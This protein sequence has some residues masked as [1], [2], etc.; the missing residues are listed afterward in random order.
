MKKKPYKIAAKAIIFQGS[1]VLILRK[2]FAE[3][4]AKDTHGWDFPG[5]GLEPEEPLMEALAREVMEETGLQV[6]VIAPAYVYDEIQEEK[7]LLII[8]FACDK[9]QGSVVL[10]PEHD[11]HHWFCVDQL[12]QTRVP[13]WMK[14]EVR[15]AYRVYNEFRRSHR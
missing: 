14:E 6:K 11:S 8:K 12:D 4:N 3:R 10:S 2:S 15:R 1:K 5:G 9:P 13:E 7:H